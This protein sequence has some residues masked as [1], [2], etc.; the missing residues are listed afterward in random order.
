[1]SS[2]FVPH[3][4]SN[5][6]D[7]RRDFDPLDRGLIPTGGRLIHS[8]DLSEPDKGDLAR[9]NDYK[10]YFDEGYT[11]ATN[12]SNSGLDRAREG[13]VGKGNHVIV[14]ERAYDSLGSLMEDSSAILVRSITQ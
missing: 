12:C 6:P 10:T 4:L 7:D 5:G 2:S 11:W 9:S 8:G 3:A 14:V 1:M 13:Y